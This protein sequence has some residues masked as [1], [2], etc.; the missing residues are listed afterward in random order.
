MVSVPTVRTFS[1]T[2]TSVGTSTR[3]TLSPSTGPLEIEILRVS[4]RCTVAPTA[5]T[6]TPRIYDTSAGAA[7][8]INQRWQG[9]VNAVGVLFDVVAVGSF[10]TTDA[11]GRFYLEPGPDA[12]ANSTFVYDITWR[13]V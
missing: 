9:S 11:G 2:A 4:I 8:S 13:V 5:T 12:G 7:G 1:G 3:I 6:F 10:L